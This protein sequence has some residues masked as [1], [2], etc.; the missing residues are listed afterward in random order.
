MRSVQSREKAPFSP[1]IPSRV[2]VSRSALTSTPGDSDMTCIITVIVPHPS[3]PMVQPWHRRLQAWI[4]WS[5]RPLASLWR[6]LQ[7]DNL[8]PPLDCHYLVVHRRCQ[9]PSARAQKKPHASWAQARQRG[10]PRAWGA[11]YKRASTLTRPGRFVPCGRDWLRR[12]APGIDS[13]YRADLDQAFNL[14]DHPQDAIRVRTNDYAVAIQKAQGVGTL[15]GKPMTRP[16]EATGASQTLLTP[17]HAA[18]VIR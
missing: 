15:E 10:A 4:D 18:I 16:S 5:S 13:V 12:A 6:I 2:R 17:R 14:A 3:T 8:I 9:A 1:T 11:I 7:S